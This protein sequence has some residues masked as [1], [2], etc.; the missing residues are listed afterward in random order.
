MGLT[1]IK[2]SGIADDSVTNAKI[3]ANAIGSS[4]L[5]DACVGTAKIVDD[6]VTA[7]KLANAINTD[8]AAKAVLTGST[9][10]TITTVTGANAIQGEAALTFDGTD[11]KVTKDLIPTVHAQNTNAASYSRV[12]LNQGSGSGGYFA[13]NKLG[14]T[15]S[16]VGGANAAQLWQSGDAPIV[17]GVN[18]T[19][20]AR[21]L[22]G[23]GLTFNGDTAAANALDDYEEGT[24]QPTVNA[25]LT[26][27]SSYNTFSYVKIGKLCHIRGLFYPGSYSGTNQVTFGLPFASFNHTGTGAAVA[28]AGGQSVMFRYIDGATGGLAVYIDDNTSSGKFYRLYGSNANWGA[29]QNDHFNSGAEIYVSFSYFTV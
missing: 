28:G 1:E 16:A 15:S 26:L 4:Q 6:A 10:N 13:I 19:E 17:I 7:D 2:T 12:I 3:A 11:L 24:Y 8:I 29:L 5:N 20:E 22:S 14:T 21:F 25:N 18:N 27:N 9:D 23:G